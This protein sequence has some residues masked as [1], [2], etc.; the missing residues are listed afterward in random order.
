MVE[1]KDHSKKG[2]RFK[3]KIEKTKEY[4]GISSYFILICGIIICLEGLYQI[5]TNTIA[6]GFTSTNSRGNLVQ[7]SNVNGSFTLFVGIV[8]CIIGIYNLPKRSK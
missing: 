3:P 5:I 8:F 4:R 7:A 2:K 6:V 1:S